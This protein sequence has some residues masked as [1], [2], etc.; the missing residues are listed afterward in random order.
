M[1]FSQLPPV[2]LAQ[3]LAGKSACKRLPV[4][5]EQW[6]LVDQMLRSLIRVKSYREAL[7]HFVG[8]ASL[9]TLSRHGNSIC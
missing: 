1:H 3:L 4:P 8:K 6:P 9:P 5:T 7:A 2:L